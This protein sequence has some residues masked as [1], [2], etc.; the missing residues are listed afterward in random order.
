MSRRTT[1][2]SP[3]L[4]ANRKIEPGADTR[5]LFPTTAN[6][7]LAVALDR[8]HLPAAGIQKY[9]V[10][11]SVF[12]VEHVCDGAGEIVERI[13]ANSGQVE[14]VFD[15]PQNRSLVSQGAIYEVLTGVWR[16][17]EQRQTRTITTA[18]LLSAQHFGG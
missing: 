17:H 15:K 8:E 3:T 9:K 11:P 10:T 18:A 16:D 1:D 14:V 5:L 13:L 4:T 12:E 2:Q 6:D 7:L